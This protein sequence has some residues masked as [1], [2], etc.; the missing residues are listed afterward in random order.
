MRTGCSNSSR[1]SA[2]AETVELGG[3]PGLMTSRSPRPTLRPRRRRSSAGRSHR[4]RSGCWRTRVLCARASILRACTRRV[5]RCVASGR[6]R[7]HTGRCSTQAGATISAVSWGGSATRWAPFV[8]STCWRSGCA[9][10]PR[11]F[12]RRRVNRASAARP[13]AAEPSGR[14]ESARVGDAAVPIRA[15]DRLA[16]RGVHEAAHPEPRCRCAGDDADAEGDGSAVVTSDEGMR[17]AR[18]PIR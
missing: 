9:G 12:P 4:R 6:R 18:L 11:C 8:T 13:A 5:W 3:I 16:R 7:G 10:T 15:P 2:R 17:R 14:Q 1:W